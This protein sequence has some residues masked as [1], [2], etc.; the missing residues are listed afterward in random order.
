MWSQSWNKVST[1][2]MDHLDLRLS[3]KH[4]S[5]TF[6]LRSRK[7]QRNTRMLCNILCTSFTSNNSQAWLCIAEGPFAEMGNHI[8]VTQTRSTMSLECM[9]IDLAGRT[10]ESPLTNAEITGYRSVLGHLLWLG[11]QSWPDL[12]GGE[13]LAAQRLSKATLS[14]VK[15]LNKLVEQAKGTAE[16]GIIIP[17]GR[18]SGNLFRCLLRRPLVSR[19]LNT[20]SRSV[21]W[22]VVSRTLLNC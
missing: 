14:D 18:E 15:T 13:S 19:T 3:C 20:R 16:M 21:V 22:S 4:M 10:L 1:T 8:K 2:C 11:Q 5:T 9:S 12:C 7:P 6:C 17:C